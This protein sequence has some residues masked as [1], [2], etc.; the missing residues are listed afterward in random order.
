L[1]LP[2]PYL[3]PNF[4]CQCSDCTIIN[5]LRICGL[6]TLG[7]GILTRWLARYPLLL[8]KDVT[9][10]AL[11][12]LIMST[13]ICNRLLWPGSWPLCCMMSS[14]KN[15]SVDVKGSRALLSGNRWNLSCS[16]S[17]H[18]PRD[19]VLPLKGGDL[20]FSGLMGQETSFM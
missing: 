8:K 17:L 16:G 1:A 3:T 6:L 7:A 11:T 19:I 13:L 18:I 15:F 4:D 5:H 10:R 12:S 9:G 14:L 20:G 2:L